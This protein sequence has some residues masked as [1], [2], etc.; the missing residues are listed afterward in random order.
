M[1]RPGAALESFDLYQR[2]LSH[3]IARVEEVARRMPP[4]RIELL[5]KECRRLS[6]I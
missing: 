6:R 3:L 5:I 4:A 2:R 1:I